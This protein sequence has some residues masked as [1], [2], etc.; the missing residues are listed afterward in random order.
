MNNARNSIIKVVAAIFVIF[1]LPL[2]C[3][4]NSTSSRDYRQDMRD[5]IQAISRYARSIQDEFIV[6]PQNGN[7]LITEDGEADGSLAPGY[8]SAI[9]GL[10]REDLYYGYS[11]D[12]SATPV[13]EVNYMVSFLD[14]AK[15]NGMTIL[16]TDY[17]Y[18]PAKMDDSYLQNL[19]KGYISFAADHR[20]LDNIPSH[21]Y[22]TG[23]PGLSADPIS[24]LSEA[25][26]FLYLINPSSYATK[27]D[28]ISAVDATEYDILLLDLF[29]EDES[30]T[31]SD[32]VQLKTKPSGS[33]RLVLAYMSIGEAEDYRYYWQSSW[34]NDPPSWL[35]E[36]NSYWPGN[37]KVRYWMKE[38]QDIIFG[39][40]GSYTKK[41]ID[42]GFN[43]VYLDI[44]DAFEYFE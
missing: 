6:I 8:L 20:E 36:E 3:S 26:N 41:I 17:C 35:A 34:M 21:P 19:S 31:I 43:G 11:D 32:L 12:D 39:N 24:T 1:W 10:G 29:F 16:V 7:E 40:D 18:T 27:A 13:K 28:F 9:D 5:F 4:C 22:P 38:W 30:L 23:H 42:A 2:Y 37:Y 44:I 15:A 33:S 14:R 25:R